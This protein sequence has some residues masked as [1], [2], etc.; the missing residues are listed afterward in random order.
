MPVN[1]RHCLKLLIITSLLLLVAGT[2]YLHGIF[3]N[4]LHKPSFA[5]VLARLPPYKRREFVW[6]VKAEIERSMVHNSSLGFDQTDLPENRECCQCQEHNVRLV[7][8]HSCP[9]EFVLLS[10]VKGSD[11]D[12][13]FYSI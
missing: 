12:D 6:N 13:N 2:A 9:P 4:K 5:E 8:I 1:L 11:N 3:G 10:N 7:Q